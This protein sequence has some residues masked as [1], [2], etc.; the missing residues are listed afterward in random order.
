MTKRK[1]Q[2]VI[3]HL[4]YNALPRV[5]RQLQKENEITGIYKKKARYITF[6]VYFIM[7]PLQFLQ[8]IIFNKK[9]SKVD[10]SK[11]QPIFILGHWRSGTTHLHYLMHKDPQYGTLSNYQ[12]FLFNVAHLSRSLLKI[13]L[14]PL[15]P[16][17]RPQDNIRVSPDL[18]AEEEQPMSVLST[19]SGIHSWNFPQNQSYFTKYNLFEGVSAKEKAEWRKDYHFLLQNI[20][21]FNDGKQLVLK[22]PHNTSRIKELLEL[23]P[24][25]K[26]INLHRNPYDVIQSTR[27]LHKTIVQGQAL[28]FFSI[29]DREEMVLTQYKKTMQ[30]NIDELH[31]IPKENFVEVRFDDLEADSMKEMERIYTTLGLP[32]FDKAKPKFEEYLSTVKNYK[33]NKFRHIRPELIERI[34]KE[35]KFVFDFYG[36]ELEEVNQAV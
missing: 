10:L 30:K 31:L 11:Q 21:F 25:A 14:S 20:T 13:V 32:N 28:Q 9:I 6:M 12:S 3:G 15:M 22:N 34:N 26:F 17:K 24:N 27:H 4:L 36:Y 18:P 33:K 19:K 5:W 16:S 8:K 2:K 35:M 1:N 23:Y 29:K 7:M